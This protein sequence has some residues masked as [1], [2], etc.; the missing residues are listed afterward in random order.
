MQLKCSR[1]RVIQMIDHEAFAVIRADSKYVIGIMPNGDE[2]FLP[3]RSSVKA[4]AAAAPELMQA[5]HSVLVARE[6]ITRVTG[7]SKHRLLHTTVGEYRISR[8]IPH[9]PF[10]TAAAANV[11]AAYRP[12]CQ[13]I[14]SSQCDALA[15]H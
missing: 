7:N 6:H 13:R 15:A 12:N 1:K 8:L 9:Q 3:H 5:S 2:W 11:L 14:K 4:I 10:V